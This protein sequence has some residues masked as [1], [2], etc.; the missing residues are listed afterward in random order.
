MPNCDAAASAGIW[1]QHRRQPT[2][3]LAAQHQPALALA[4]PNASLAALGLPFL[5]PRQPHNRPY[6]YARCVGGAGRRLPLSRLLM[7]PSAFIGAPLRRSPPV[8]NRRLYVIL[9][10]WPCFFVPIFAGV[11]QMEIAERRCVHP[12]VAEVSSSATP[13][14]RLNETPRSRDI[15]PN[16]SGRVVDTATLPNHRN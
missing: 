5:A 11:C 1:R 3:L 14:S 8:V 2:W 9:I 12:R 16:Q 7:V 6:P 4:F 10:R 15:H 13:R